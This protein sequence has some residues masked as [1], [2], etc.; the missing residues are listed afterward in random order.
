[1]MKARLNEASEAS[2]KKKITV[3]CNVHINYAMPLI[4]KSNSMK[5]YPL[6]NQSDK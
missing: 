1:M 6:L 2:Q 5:N 4:R 3:N